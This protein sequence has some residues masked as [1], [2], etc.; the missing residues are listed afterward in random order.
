M[1]Q[2][3]KAVNLDKKEY[4]CPWCLSGGA[5][6]WEWSANTQGSIFTLLLRKS[7]EGGGGDFHGYHNGHD[8]GT[9]VLHPDAIAGRWAGDRV[10]LLGDY[11]ESNLWTQLPSYRNI[12]QQLVEAW[13]PY[14]GLKEM[15][16]EWNPDCRCNQREPGQVSDDP[17]E[18]TREDSAVTI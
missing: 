8:E 2:Y 3:F 10:V 15:L 6:L 13:N 4:V 9:P 16:L 12:T 7:S 11:D 5:K 18:P 17:R 1:G 14:I